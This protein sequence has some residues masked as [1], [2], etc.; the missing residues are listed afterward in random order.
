MMFGNDPKDLARTL[1]AME[2]EAREA[3][4]FDQIAAKGKFREYL[5]RDY[6]FTEFDHDRLVSRVME[7]RSCGR[8]LDLDDPLPQAAE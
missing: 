4:N 8:T 3:C 6:R 5:S 1:G 2:R 7:A